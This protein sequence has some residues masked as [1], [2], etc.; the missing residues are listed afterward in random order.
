MSKYPDSRY[1]NI[2]KEASE[3]I[4]IPR[5]LSVHPGGIIISPGQL[6]DLVPLYL[7]TKGIIITQFDLDSIERL[8]LVKIDLL[9]TR[10]LTVIGRVADKI[11]SW[12]STEYSKGL[13]VLESI[14]EDDLDTSNLQI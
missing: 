5:Y 12:R 6:T 7:A 1:Q 14:P 3:L 11:Q 8:G 4:G 2:F 13:D 10:G 9:G